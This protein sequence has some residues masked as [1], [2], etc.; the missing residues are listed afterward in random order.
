MIENWDGQ[1]PGDASVP[2]AYWVQLVGADAAVCG[3]DAP[4]VIYWTP[5]EQMPEQCDDND[6]PLP[7]AGSWFGPEE[8][9]GPEELLKNYAEC[10]PMTLLGRAYTPAEVSEQVAQA[11]ARGLDTAVALCEGERLGAMHNRTFGAALG[12][13]WCRDA[14]RA[15]LIAG[16]GAPVFIGAKAIAAVL[17]ALDAR[18]V[19]LNHGHGNVSDVPDDDCIGAAAIIR[20][21]VTE[22]DAARAGVP[23]SA[24]AAQRALIEL[25]EAQSECDRARAEAKRL[26][27]VL[28]II[29]VR[30]PLDIVAICRAALATDAG[31]G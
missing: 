10:L 28:Q 26:R 7:R 1:P 6:N 21:L 14:V 13:K 16:Y 19:L 4:F 24:D 27:E 31:H 3:M 11:R 30:A 12:A 2:A 8:V 29:R 5:A 22:R 20:A 18:R 25:A 15:K 17:A 9:G 23:Q